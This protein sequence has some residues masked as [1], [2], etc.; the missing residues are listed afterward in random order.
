M[1]EPT[2]L[3]QLKNKANLMGIEFH[4]SIKEDKLRAKIKEKLDESIP[5]APVIEMTERQKQNERRNQLRREATKL[6]RVEITCMNPNKAEYPG[7]IFTVS[8]SVVGTIKK[9]VP[10]NGEPWHVE[11]AILNVIQDRKYQAFVK[12]KTARG[13]VVNE[14]K[15][16]REFSVNILPNLTEEEITDLAHQ[17]AIANNLD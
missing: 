17:Q 5:K 1:S 13:D 6:V 10:F 8:N 2:E 14:G 4:P 9:F 15:Q 7:E 11:Q 3:E 12:R 16:V